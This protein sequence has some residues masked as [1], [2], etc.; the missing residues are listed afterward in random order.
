V[1]CL[2]DWLWLFRLVLVSRWWG[3][4]IHCHCL[5]AR[6]RWGSLNTSTSNT[7]RRRRRRRRIVVRGGIQ[8]KRKKKTFLLG[9]LYF[10]V[11]SGPL[12]ADCILSTLI[13]YCCCYCC[14]AICT[15]RRVCVSWDDRKSFGAWF[16]CSTRAMGRT[17]LSHSLVVNPPPPSAGPLRLGVLLLPTSSTS[18]NRP[19]NRLNAHPSRDR[20][21]RW[22]CQTR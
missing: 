10:L 20:A 14:L 5:A 4:I 18:I 1:L 22:R 2:C 12:W 9:F 13:S 7:R 17:N 21:G 19:S 16:E 8:K 15:T 3:S 6:H 11:P